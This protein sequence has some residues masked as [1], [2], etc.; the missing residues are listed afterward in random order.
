MSLDFKSVK[1][2]RSVA[3]WLKEL[4]NKSGVYVI[5]E[6]GWLGQVLYVGESHTGDL[7][8]KSHSTL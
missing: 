2:G 1:D 5:R 8:L 3:K 4:K 7:L 6:R